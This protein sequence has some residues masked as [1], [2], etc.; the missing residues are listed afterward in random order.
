MAT[1]STQM[2]GTLGSGAGTSDQQKLICVG[3]DGTWCGEATGTLSNIQML[4]ECMAGKP[5]APENG[6]A[7]FDRPGDGV[8]IVGAYFQG[9]GLT[10]PFADYI[11]NA[12]TADDIK[13]ACADAYKFIV[14]HYDDSSRIVLFGLSRGAF[15]IRSVAGMINNWGILDKS[16]LTKLNLSTSKE[17]ADALLDV[18]V[19]TV[20]YNYRSPDPKYAPNSAYAQEFKEVFSHA[21]GCPR[22]PPIL[23]MGLLDTVGALGVPKLNA[24]ISFGYEFY[25]N[26]VSSEVQ[27]CYQALS[28]HDRLFFFQPCFAQRADPE[29]KQPRAESAWDKIK[30]SWPPPV[31][32][33]VWHPGA[34]Y[35]I[36]HQRFVFPRVHIP[37]NSFGAYVESFVGFLSDKFNILGL[38]IEPTPEYSR[39]VLTWMMRAMQKR[40][41]GLF[42]AEI[43]SSVKHYYDVKG[44]KQGRFYLLPSH[45]KNAADILAKAYLGGVK[46]ILPFFKMAI[47]DRTIPQYKPAATFYSAS[48]KAC[49]EVYLH[50]DPPDPD[51]DPQSISGQISRCFDT[52]DDLKGPKQ[53]RWT[54]GP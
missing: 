9:L 31:T 2:N 30:D 22:L 23:F 28:T 44:Q 10:G 4:A 33:E 40:M 32:V 47:L 37:R 29:Q 16:K 5:L 34:H 8:H 49:P 43:E 25:D 7:E 17:A 52:Y 50:G 19:D 35:D 20:Y 6:R 14:E 45:S 36:G 53:L 41:P 12:V 27:I 3:C 38:N 21:K 51:A 46:F 18:Y 15:T 54:A 26:I 48:G 13:Q 24:G 42:N 39:G 1:N 11:T